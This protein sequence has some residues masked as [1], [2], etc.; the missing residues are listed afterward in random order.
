MSL[1]SP[2][3][4]SVLAQIDSLGPPG[5]PVTTDEV[6]AGFDCTR[7]RLEAVFESLLRHHLLQT[8]AVGEGCRIWWRPPGTT[9]VESVGLAETDTA[10]QNT[11]QPASGAHSLPASGQHPAQLY[12]LVFNQTVQFTGI[13]EPDGTLIDANE[14]AL[15]FGGLAREE[16]IGRPVWETDWWTLTPETQHRLKHAVTQAAAGETVRYVVT[17]QGATRTVPID[18]SL[19][20]IDDGEVT[21]LIAEGRDISDLKTTER[22]LRQQRDALETELS[23]VLERV[24]DGVYSLDSYRRFEYVNDHAQ[25]LLGIEESVVRGQEISEAIETTEQFRTRLKTAIEDQNPVFFEDY[26]EPLDAW[27]DN[28]IYPSES[29]VSVFFRDISERKRLEL[30]LRTETEHFQTVLTNS[31]VVAFRQDTD[32]RYTWIGNPREGFS[33]T[34]VIGKRDNELLPAEAAAAVMEPKQQALDTGQRV[35][36]EVTLAFPDGDVIYDLTVDPIFDEAGGCI[37]LAATTVDL[38]EQ[39]R[40]KAALR[41]SEER[42]QLALQAGNL[43]TWELDLRTEDSPVRSLEHDRIF[44]YSE[45]IDDWS[46]EIFLDH[47][48]PDDRPAVEAGFEAGF[49]TGEWAFECRIERAD[50][51]ERWIAA[52]GE[53]HMD[54][55]GELVRAVGVVSDI[56]DRMDRQRALEASEQRYRTLVANFPNGGVALLDKKLRHRVVDGLGFEAIGFD[57]ETLAGKRV[58]EVFPAE[59]AAVLESAYRETLD[60]EAH[61]LEVDIGERTCEFRT[62]PVTD[63]DGETAVLSIF[64]DIT[65]HKTQQERQLARLAE[66]HKIVQDVAHLIITASTRSEIEQVICDR[67]DDAEPYVGAWVGRPDHTGSTI[68]PSAVSHD[69]GTGSASDSD[70]DAKNVVSEQ[71]VDLLN[72]SVSVDP[73]A[74]SIGGPIAAAIETARPQLI[75]TS[76][77]DHIYAQWCLSALDQHRPGVVVPI[78]HESRVYGVIVIYTNR[79]AFEPRELETLG[80]LGRIVGH[81]INAI[82]RKRA[83]MGGRVTEVVVRS[84]ALAE[85]FLAAADDESLTISIDHVVTL[86]SG[87]SL[88]YYTTE[89]ITPDQFTAMI[90]ELT[91]N[92]ELRLLEQVGTRSRLEL[93]TDAETLHSIVAGHGGWIT[94]AGI[95]DGSFDITIRVPLGTEVR[96]VLDAARTMYP[97]LRLVSQTSVTPS[98]RTALDAFANLTTELTDR[99]REVLEIGFYAGFFE[100]P[101]ETTGDE[102]AEL[103]GVAPPTVHH[104]LRHGQQKLLATFFEQTSQ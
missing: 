58:A 71:P 89:G 23:S 12:G 72:S 66:L 81:A 67:F 3:T 43:G 82:D 27:L 37:G 73:D 102:L 84:D 74:S 77:T 104:H 4:A 91:D 15:Q 19:R 31:P 1:R 101:R 28:A 55:D 65:L 92:S 86:K 8:K 57:V 61:T 90:Q 16:V 103:I 96:S 38:T 100:W 40:T 52:A 32:L 63:A 30:E 78:H 99:Q 70:A 60:G 25:S 80:R 75:H 2:S 7:E 48:H 18:F 94:T 98:R 76:P 49:E 87:R 35:R 29:G 21:L 53:F 6:A 26:Y 24:S 45:G 50:G 79:E 20:P 54:D 17:V 97:D 51:V 64:H 9:S 95:R 22:Q 68:H 33:E 59:I 39:S 41:S 46:F 88:I 10:E 93:S 62:L 47:V 56:T 44:G 85:A 69:S 14:S 5:T 11:P 36:K 83:L 34:E 13:L 42:L